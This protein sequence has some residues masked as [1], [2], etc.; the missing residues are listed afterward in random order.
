MNKTIKFPEL[1]KSKP[2]LI[3]SGFSFLFFHYLWADRTPP[4]QWGGS[5]PDGGLERSWWSSTVP[6]RG[7]AGSRAGWRGSGGTGTPPTPPLWCGYC[8]TSTPHTPA[9]PEETQNE[10]HDINMMFSV[11]LVWHMSSGWVAV[12][13]KRSKH[14]ASR[15]LTA[16]SE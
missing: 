5:L 14:S 11:A 7:V 10:A 8:T 12:N 9:N 6:V 3:P 1:W 2:F 16:R 15:E 4:P 13:G